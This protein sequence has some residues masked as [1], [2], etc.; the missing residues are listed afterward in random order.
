MKLPVPAVSHQM[1]KGGH[2]RGLP[3]NNHG[4]QNVRAAQQLPE[5]SF[6]TRL[7]RREHSPDVSK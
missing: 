5:A 2:L 6:L 3:K 7:Q 1:K 4:K